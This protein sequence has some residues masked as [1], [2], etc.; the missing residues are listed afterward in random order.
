MKLSLKQGPLAVCQLAADA[1]V[2]AWATTRG[3]FT[4]LSRT[5]EEL[6]IVCPE[7]VV[8]RGVKQEKGWRMFQ[9]DGPLDF[10]LTGVL[11][12]LAAPLAKAGVGIFVL[13]TYNT[14]YVLVKDAQVAEAVAAEGTEAIRRRLQLKTL[15]FGMGET[16]RT[17]ILRKTT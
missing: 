11:A 8:P 6:S 13:S 7:G 9:V 15:L 4:S 12:S 10:A 5:R 2:P 1:P 16:F 17:Q 3:A 14:D